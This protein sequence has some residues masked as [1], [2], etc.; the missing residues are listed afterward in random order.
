M[1]KEYEV[2]NNYKYLSDLS[3]KFGFRQLVARLEVH[4]IFSVTQKLPIASVSHNL[5]IP[6]YR[7]KISVAKNKNCCKIVGNFFRKMFRKMCNEKLWIKN[8]LTL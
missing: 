6:T 4:N 8:N 2:G 7:Y 3:H 5:Q 1:L